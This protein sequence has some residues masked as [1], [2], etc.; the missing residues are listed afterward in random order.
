MYHMF[1]CG[2]SG[3]HSGMGSIRVLPNMQNCMGS[4][5]VTG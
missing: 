5:R 4:I 2:M 3:I 1:F